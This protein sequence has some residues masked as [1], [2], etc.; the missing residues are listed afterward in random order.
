MKQL[1]TLSFV[2]LISYV[3]YSQEGVY[4]KD[5]AK[6]EKAVDERLNAMDESDRRLKATIQQFP[7]MSLTIVMDYPDKPASN[8]TIQYYFKGYECASV[9]NFEKN[10]NSSIDRMIMNFKEGKSLILSTDRK[11]R[12]TGMKMDMK[13]I[14]M[15]A[16]SAVSKEND[17]LN[18]GK[19]SLRSTDE[20]KMIEGYKCRKYIHEGE[21]YTSEIWVTEDAKLDHV[22]L[23]KALAQAFANT[24]GPS[25]NAY[26]EAGI[27]G[28]AIQTH[29]SPKD[30]RSQ[31]C[32]MTMKNIKPG[33]APAEMFSTQG[34]E[35]TEMPSMKNMWDSYK[36]DN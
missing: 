4:S 33:V 17:N 9:M 1:F 26:V 2:L 23:N 10:R 20:I 8:M 18:K 5:R 6:G 3:S 13:G 14:N 34:Y 28:L 25:Q 16:K 19:S 21:K 7:A 36:K 35:V 29:M 30:G 24:S 27:K 22:K 11:G 32:T 12:K 15:I 31:E